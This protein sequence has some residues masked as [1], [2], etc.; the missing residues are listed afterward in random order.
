MADSAIGMKEMAEVL[1]NEEDSL[2]FAGGA[3]A[4]LPAAPLSDALCSAF[5]TGIGLSYEETSRMSPPNAHQTKRMLGVWTKQALAPVIIPNIAAG[6]V[7]KKLQQGAM[8]LDMGC[9][10]GVAV[11]ALA[12]AFPASTIHGVD[13]DSFAILSAQEDAA[14]QGLT[15]C[16]FCIAK[17]EALATGE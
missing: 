12:E 13:P 3:F 6:A 7:L 8:V 16:S 9:G 11:N 10:A 17:G 15:N 4:S 2:R 1:A 14:T 5:K